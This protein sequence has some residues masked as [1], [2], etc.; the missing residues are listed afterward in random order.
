MTT[1]PK[2]IAGPVAAAA[3]VATVA[4]TVTAAVPADAVIPAAD[5]VLGKLQ[6]R[7][8]L[9]QTRHHSADPAIAAIW[10]ESEALDQAYG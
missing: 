2:R 4:V 3:A 6:T 1:P 9:C 5:A 10:W 7:P 8:Q